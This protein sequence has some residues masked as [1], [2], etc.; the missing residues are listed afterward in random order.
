MKEE[1]LTSNIM[2]HNGMQKNFRTKRYF[3]YSD[4]EIE[5]RE[6]LY[7]KKSQRLCT[8]KKYHN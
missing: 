6:A 7:K 4:K 2:L 8:V 1:R 5:I 3:F